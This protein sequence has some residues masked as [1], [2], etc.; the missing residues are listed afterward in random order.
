MIKGLEHLSY[1][2]KLREL[3]LFCMKSSRLKVDLINVYKY[4]K[5][6][7]KEGGARLLSVVPS[8]RTRGNGHKLKHRRFSLTI[9]KHLFTMRATEHWHRLPREAAESPSSETL[10]SCLDIAV[11]KSRWSCLSRGFGL[12][13][14]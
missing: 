12:D 13:E 5:G 11:G 14:R 2:E 6:G 4:L 9:R 1:E 3:E 7:C 10:K 8:T